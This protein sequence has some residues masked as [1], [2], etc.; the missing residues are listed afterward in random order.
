[1]SLITTNSSIN[2]QQR[3]LIKM[4]TSS[5]VY[6]CSYCTNLHK[7]YV[8]KT[9]QALSVKEPLYAIITRIVLCTLLKTHVAVSV[10]IER[11]TRR[12]I[13]TLSPQ[14]IN[15]VVSTYSNLSPF[16]TRR[17]SFELQHQEV[18]LTLQPIRP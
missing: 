5:K 1:M 7:L 8:C 6:S 18:H 4:Q 17:P 12:I 14:K 13:A 16:H 3:V 9:F 10:N 2:F 11:A 15:Q